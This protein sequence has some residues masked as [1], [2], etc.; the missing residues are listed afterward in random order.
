MTYTEFIEKIK[1]KAHEELNYPLETME[2]F[3]E[4]YTSNDP[5]MVEWII[6]SNARFAGGD[7]SPWLKTDFLVLKRDEGI[8]VEDGKDS[9]ATMQRIAI[10]KLYQEV[11]TNSQDKR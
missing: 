5:K 7:P 6:D 9:V 8:K 2:F 1:I 11:Q 4:G 3:P 10:R